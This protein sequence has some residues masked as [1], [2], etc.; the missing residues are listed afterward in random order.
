MLK[1]ILVRLLKAK[2]SSVLAQ[3]FRAVAEGDFGEKAKAVYW[4]AAGKKTR[5]GVLLLAVSLG[6]KALAGYPNDFPW[7]P[8]AAEIVFGIG[9]F[10]VTVGLSD[11]L[12]REEPPIG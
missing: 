12:A 4:W 7:A 10:L 11:G 6:L 5:T 2:W 1:S 8:L 9:T 3:L